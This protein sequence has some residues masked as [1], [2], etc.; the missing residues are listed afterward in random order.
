MYKALNYWVFGG[1]DGQKSPREFIDFAAANGLDGI[2]LTVG[3]ALNTDITEEECKSIAAY[4]KEI[5][6]SLIVLGRQGRGALESLRRLIPA[7]IG[8]AIPVASPISPGRSVSS[9]ASS[10]AW[11]RVG[12]AK[13]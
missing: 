5:D 10:H 3:D 2:E 7:P 9:R 4:A 1:F 6:P 13:E 11:S 12:G 8:E